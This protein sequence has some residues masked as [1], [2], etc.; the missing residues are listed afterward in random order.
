MNL[1]LQSCSLENV[2]R[3][4]RSSATF[5]HNRRLH[6]DSWRQA[7]KERLHSH[8][9]RM[10]TVA[11]APLPHGERVCALRRRRAARTGAC[12][13]IGASLKDS[14]VCNGWVSRTAT[15]STGCVCQQCLSLVAA[16]AT[17]DTSKFY[18]SPSCH[19]CVLTSEL[20][21]HC[22]YFIA[23]SSVFRSQT[24][25]RCRS[26][27]TH[28]RSTSER[29]NSRWLRT[30]MLADC[31]WRWLR[32]RELHLLVTSMTWTDSMQFAANT[33]SGFTLK[34]GWPVPHF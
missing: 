16:S 19:N 4:E 11:V 21:C 13:P 33:N 8:S 23:H 12:P 14:H 20:L 5:A 34:G 3:P 9:R 26:T 7:F 32:L 18:P 27:A 31:Q 15:T 6:V 2:G 1:I 30:R 28:K 29:S 10:H 25:S 24:S 22:W 17:C